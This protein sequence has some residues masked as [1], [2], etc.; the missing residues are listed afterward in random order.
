MTALVLENARPI[1]Q[2]IVD[3]LRLC[4]P[5]RNLAEATR[6]LRLV[7]CIAESA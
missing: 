1:N 5:Y 4:R 7:G 2:P 6:D 3:T